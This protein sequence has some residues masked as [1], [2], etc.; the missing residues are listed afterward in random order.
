MARRV[1]S[2]NLWRHIVRSSRQLK[3]NE[4]E[5]YLHDARTNFFTHAQE[6]DP[7]RLKQLVN[8]GYA[9]VKWVI[10]FRVHGKYEE[11]P[12][13]GQNKEESQDQVWRP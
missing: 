11:S 13:M 9:K 4:R 3:H 10:D 7:V 1:E 5:Y 2:L 12:D 8:A 6:E